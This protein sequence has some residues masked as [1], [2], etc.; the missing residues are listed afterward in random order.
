MVSDGGPA[1]S[2]VWVIFFEIQQY[3][4]W[5]HGQ[6]WAQAAHRAEPR[7]TWSTGITYK[8]LCGGLGVRAGQRLRKNIHDVCV[9]APP[10]FAFLKYWSKQRSW[11]KCLWKEQMLQN[12]TKGKF[13]GSGCIMNPGL[14]ALPWAQ[15]PHSHWGL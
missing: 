15:A 8:C 11:Q 9:Q 5:D 2:K 3:L 13:Q 4:Q 7:G 12:F 6:Q 10:L 14:M 1:G